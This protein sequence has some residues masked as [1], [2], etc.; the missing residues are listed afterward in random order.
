MKKLLRKTKIIFLVVVLALLT[1][2]IPLFGC[3]MSNFEL[4]QRDGFQGTLTEWLELQRGENAFEIA[5]RHGFQGTEAEWLASL[6]VDSFGLNEI[7]EGWYEN[8]LSEGHG[9]TLVEV[10]ERFIRVFFVPERCFVQLAMHRALRSTVAIRAGFNFIGRPSATGSGSGVLLRIDRD[11]GVS[12]IVTNYH[13]IFYQDASPSLSRSIRIAPIG[14][15]F[16]G[17]GASN[18]DLSI[19]AEFV[20]GSRAL[21]VAVLRTVANYALRNSVHQPAAIADSNLVIKG[22]T[23]I[24]IGSPGFGTT[25]ATVGVVNKETEDIRMQALDSSFG[26]VWHRVMRID[27]AINPGNSG[28]GVFNRMGQLIGIVMAKQVAGA[29]DNIGYAIPSNV[30]VGVARNVMQNVRVGGNV[31]RYTIGATTEIIGSMPVLL[32]GTFVV[33]REDIAVTNV[34]A[35]SP[36]ALGGLRVS[37]VLRTAQLADYDPIDITRSFMLPDYLLRAR[38]DDILTLTVLR[39]S[40]L[41]ELTITISASHHRPL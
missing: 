15:E 36:A 16:F 27:A 40:Q 5:L 3:A 2:T 8:T 31:I 34:A 11:T 37:D 17:D 20:G 22:D 25:S 19:Q 28:G 26:L 12:Y 6:R 4:A 7:F 10:Y 21:D 18:L 13:V 32:N 38:A 23:A 30:A 41:V 14:R 33:S 35:N 9:Y 39:G 1:F 24:A 29:I